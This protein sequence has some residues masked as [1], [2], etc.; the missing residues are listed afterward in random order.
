MKATLRHTAGARRADDAMR[1]EL[2]HQVWSLR[3]NLGAA[4]GRRPA[5]ASPP[6][7]TND[8]AEPIEAIP[9]ETT[10]RRTRW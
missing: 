4:G 6:V 7:T 2:E 10:P 1:F 5:L 3:E 9:V 8:L